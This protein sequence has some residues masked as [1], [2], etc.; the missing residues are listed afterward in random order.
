MLP[1]QFAEIKY[2]LVL[3][4]VYLFKLLQDFLIFLI[5]TGDLFCFVVAM[6]IITIESILA[7]L[8]LEWFR[9]LNVNHIEFMLIHALEL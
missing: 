7:D 8:N 1:D 2:A 9:K 3:Y 5:S 4:P 6:M